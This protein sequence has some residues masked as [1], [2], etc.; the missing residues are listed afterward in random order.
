MKVLFLIALCFISTLPKKLIFVQ[1]IFRHG[2]RYPIYEVEH[3]T[4]GSTEY[5]MGE[6]TTQG[7]HMQY[8]LGRIMYDQYWK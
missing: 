3:D 5:L 8:I 2:A 6:L 7:K 4:S 1:E